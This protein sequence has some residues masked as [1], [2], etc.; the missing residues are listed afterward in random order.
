ML[1]WQL[2]AERE[3]AAK[4]ELA[5]DLE[6]AGQADKAAALRRRIE[7]PRPRGMRLPLAGWLARLA[8]WPPG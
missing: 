4:Y 5:S 2:Q 7:V 8:G 1:C 3:R 6:E